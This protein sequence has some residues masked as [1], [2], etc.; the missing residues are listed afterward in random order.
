MQTDEAREGE[1]KGRGGCKARK[2]S[3]GGGA[4]KYNAKGQGIFQERSARIQHQ[5]F[6]SLTAQKSV[7]ALSHF[8]SRNSSKTEFKSHL[9]T[10]KIFEIK[11]FEATLKEFCSSLENFSP[12]LFVRIIHGH[13]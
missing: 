12:K 1:A 9:K 7:L 13:D 5:N 8:A 2:R 4:E 10:H 11:A 3:E 6:T